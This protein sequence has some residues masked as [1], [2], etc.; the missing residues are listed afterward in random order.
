MEDEDCLH[1]QQALLD[2][3]HAFALFSA[4][5]GHRCAVLAFEYAGVPVSLSWQSAAAHLPALAQAATAVALPLSES[6][7]HLSEITTL[8]AEVDAVRPLSTTPTT[9]S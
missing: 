7:D 3:M 9:N 6:R 1:D 5:Y 8:D 2:A 4:Q